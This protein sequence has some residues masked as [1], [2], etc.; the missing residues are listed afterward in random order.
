MKNTFKKSIGYAFL[1]LGVVFSACS[2]KEILGPSIEGLYGPLTVIETLKSSNANPDFTKD[3]SIYFTAKFSSTV[4]WKLTIK[5]LTT[6]ATDTLSGMSSMLDSTN[7]VW[8][9]HAN[10]L[11]SFE[12]EN[13][14]VLLSFRNSTDTIKTTIT[15]GGKQNIFNQGIVVSNFSTS[16]KIGNGWDKDWPAITNANT[17][18]TQIDGNGYLLMSGKPWQ[19]SPITPYVN[20]L[21]IPAKYADGGKPT[22]VH[23]PLGSD[24]NKVYFNIFVYATETQDTWLKIMFLEDGASRYINIRPDWT[25]WKLISVKYAD[26]TLE[27]TGS[28]TGE[29]HKLAAVQFVLLSDAVPAESV[30]VSAAF[31]HPVFTI[32]TP[33]RP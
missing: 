32:D 24:P 26:L 3:K 13:I 11:P 29:P 21:K 28:A 15:L 27:G 9:G 12:L 6:G 1:L 4:S 22:D 7:A 20:F 16:S 10:T 25:G 5:G 14:E 30:S 31:D 33:F 18:Y 2:K 8:D 19:G 17:S 23:Y